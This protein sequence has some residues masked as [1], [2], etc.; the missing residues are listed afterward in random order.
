MGADPQLQSE[1]E[2]LDTTRTSPQFK[3]P[4]GARSF[5]YVVAAAI[6]AAL[7]FV[8]NNLLE[9]DVLPWL[10]AD[11]Q[12]VVGIVSLS[13]GAS[14]AAN[15][16][17]AAYDAPWFKSVGEIVMAGFGFA[18]AVRLFQVFPFDFSAYDFNWGLV[19]RVVL[20][21]AMVGIGISVLVELGK[22]AR[23]RS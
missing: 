5:G 11:F 7:I 16:A 2:S 8:V 21:L 13:L 19:A 3:V 20:I 22:L 10:T 6:N 12:R 15:L 1:R 23:N 14:V 18:A 4:R 9:W 17:F